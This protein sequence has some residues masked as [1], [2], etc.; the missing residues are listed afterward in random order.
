M[1]LFCPVQ[2]VHVNGAFA[3]DAEYRDDALVD[4]TGAEQ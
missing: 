1:T 4:Q 2:F 3:G